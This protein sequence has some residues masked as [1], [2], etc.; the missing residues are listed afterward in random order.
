MT[1]LIAIILMIFT[2]ILHVLFGS[3][4]V[5]AG[6]ISSSVTTRDGR[7]PADCGAIDVTFDDQPAARASESFTIPTGDA[8]A[9]RAVLPSG[10]GVRVTG[11]DRDEYAVTV[12]KAA[13]DGATLSR[14]AVAHQGGDLTPSG[15]SG[16]A[17][18]VYLLVRAPRG[19]SLDFEA[20]NGSIDVK[21]VSGKIR[22]RTRNG[23]VSLSGCDAEIVATTENGPI[24]FSGR[25]RNVDLRANNG[26]VS[27]R[28]EGSSWEGGRLTA[29]TRNGP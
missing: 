5:Y 18:L 6:Q 13:R 16:D 12:C 3:P 21:G 25:G 9:L 19:A 4:R 15:P 29:R 27:V 14:V 17:W 20:R 11:W 1:K 26:P 10:S 8:D 24:S 22:A 28:L 23:P 2:A 7:S